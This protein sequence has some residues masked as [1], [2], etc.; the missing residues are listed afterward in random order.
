MTAPSSSL[1]L[2]EQPPIVIVGAGGMGRE[3]LA[4]VR[5]SYPHG[6]VLGYL[7]DGIPVGDPVCDLAV[8]GATDWI[9][10][11]DIAAVIAIGSPARR[12]QVVARLEHA[13]VPLLTVV[14]PTA[15]IG[16]GVVLG[17]GT[18]VCPNVTLTRDVRVGVSAILNYGCQVGHDSAIGDFALIAPGVALA[19]NVTVG[20]G[21]WVGIG[22]SVIEGVTVGAWSTIGAGSAV[23]RNVPGGATAVGVPCRP[24]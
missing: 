19:G 2:M 22:A 5:D 7:D 1:V 13:G 14:H 15:Y 24:V 21:A 20:D 3:A 17:A 11:Q 16:P 23:I 6:E 18:I 12:E 9:T 10:D 4:W 8:L